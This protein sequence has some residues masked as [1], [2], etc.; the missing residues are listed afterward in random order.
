MTYQLRD[1]KTMKMLREEDISHVNA[2]VTC[3][4][5]ENLDY[6]FKGS[7]LN[8][9]KQYEDIDILATGHSR[10][11]ERAAK[12]LLTNSRLELEG[13]LY[14]ITDSGSPAKYVGTEVDHRFKIKPVGTIEDTVIDLSLKS[15]DLFSKSIDPYMER[16]Y[17]KICDR[18]REASR[19]G[20]K[21]I[22]PPSWL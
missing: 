22:N 4:N 5:F 15:K 16:K 11:I 12:N 18:M 7:M 6:E 8:G 10:D 20:V 9:D 3:L 1:W 14:S 19:E 2:I 17:D 13:Q 21:K